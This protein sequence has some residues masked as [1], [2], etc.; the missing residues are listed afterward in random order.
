MCGVH[1]LSSPPLIL[2][3]TYMHSSFFRRPPSLCTPPPCRRKFGGKLIPSTLSTLIRMEQAVDH[4]EWKWAN[5]NSSYGPP[6]FCNRIAQDRCPTCLS[7]DLSATECPQRSNLHQWCPHAQFV[8]DSTPRGAPLRPAHKYRHI[9]FKCHGTHC[10][11]LRPQSYRLTPHN[12]N[13]YKDTR[14]T[15]QDSSFRS[16]NGNGCSTPAQLSHIQHTTVMVH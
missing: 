9:C 11:S 6:F 3:H 10:R 5:V 16:R 4:Q 13:N 12:S 14:E 2:S 8:W 7:L 1:F 15:P